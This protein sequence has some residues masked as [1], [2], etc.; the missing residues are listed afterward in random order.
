MSIIWPLHPASTVSLALGSC[1]ITVAAG[2]QA[3]QREPFKSKS[4][5]ATPL[6]STLKYF[7]VLHLTHHKSPSCFMIS[8]TAQHHPLLHLHLLQLFPSSI[9]A[10]FYWP[11]CWFQNMPPWDMAP[12]V[13]SPLPILTLTPLLWVLAVGLSWLFPLKYTTLDFP[14]CP[15]VKILCFHCTG[16]EFDFWLGN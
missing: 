6:G 1:S 9:H 15:V 13:P 3:S 14:G 7:R 16:Y 10:Q 12:A 8:P 2:F 4:D 11:P 5:E